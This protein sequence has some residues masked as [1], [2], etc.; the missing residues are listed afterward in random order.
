MRVA[1]ERGRR[2]GWALWSSTSQI[3]L[4][5]M[6]SVRRVDGP[7]TVRRSESEID[8]RALFASRLRQAIA[9]RATLAI[10]ATA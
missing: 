1:S 7:A 8:E 3:A 5:M 2:L 10:D 9:Y 4:R 6:L